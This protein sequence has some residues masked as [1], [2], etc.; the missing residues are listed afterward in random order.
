MDLNPL[1]VLIQNLHRP[2]VLVIDDDCYQSSFPVQSP[3]QRYK[4]LGLNRLAIHVLIS[5]IDCLY[6]TG[7]LK[8]GRD[9][10]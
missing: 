3:A 10:S 7:A 2:D 4:I 5:E 6:G 9:L 8:R 1:Q